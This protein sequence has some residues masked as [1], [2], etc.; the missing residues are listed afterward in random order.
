MENTIEKHINT[1]DIDIDNL[2]LDDEWIKKF[3]EQE[4]DYT[5]FYKEPIECVKVLSIFINNENDII[6]VSK[7]QILL[8]N[9]NLNKDLLMSFIEKKRN[10]N[11]KKYKLYS[12]LKYNIDIDPKEL[13]NNDYNNS[14]YLTEQKY[15][16]DIEFKDTINFF[17]DLNTL[18]LFF[19]ERN[20]KNIK[21]KK[22]RSKKHF[23]NI[24][25]LNKK[26]R[27]K[28]C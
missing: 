18:F 13:L 7:N 11:G 10:C 2:T 16:T 8:D 19:K 9:S 21:H 23:L 26:T 17:N 14:Q 24:I 1:N 5:Y 12:I 22:T 15:I 25:K 4:K 3:Y 20:N 28:K 27:S 6:R